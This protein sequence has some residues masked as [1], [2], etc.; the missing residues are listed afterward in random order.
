MRVL[1][2]ARAALRRLPRTSELLADFSRLVESDGSRPNVERRLEEVLRRSLKRTV[3]VIPVNT[4][5]K[6]ETGKLRDHGAWHMDRRTIAA[7]V[8]GGRREVTGAS[9]LAAVFGETPGAS[10]RIAALVPVTSSTG[11]RLAT[12][13][14]G[15]RRFSFLPLSDTERS[16]I[17]AAVGMAT[18]LLEQAQ[19]RDAIGVAKE[20][21][22]V[23]DI[24]M[25]HARKVRRHFDIDGSKLN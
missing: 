18:L 24:V 12:V 15:K 16:L 20:A 23:K 21:E 6:G 17:A 2:W 19:L 5:P 13:V 10:A 8:E 4:P 1:A 11:S 14:V 22:T 7:W 3:A 25:D 9:K